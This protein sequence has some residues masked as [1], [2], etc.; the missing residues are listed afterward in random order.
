[1][2]HIYIYIS[3]CDVLMYRFNL[4]CELMVIGKLVDVLLFPKFGAYFGIPTVDTD[5]PA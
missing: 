2:A 4:S 5:N 1:M 3:H